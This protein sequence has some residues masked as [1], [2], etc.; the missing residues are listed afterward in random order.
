[1]T[2]TDRKC[3]ALALF[4]LEDWFEGRFEDDQV[5]ALA[6]DLQLAAHEW[7]VAWKAANA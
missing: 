6:T 3:Q 7:L 2:T 1:M 4:F 5:D